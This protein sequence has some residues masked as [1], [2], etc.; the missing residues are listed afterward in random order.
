MQSSNWTVM[1]PPFPIQ[2]SFVSMFLL[3]KRTSSKSKILGLGLVWGETSCM[4]YFVFQEKPKVKFSGMDTIS[5][6]D[7]DRKEAR[8]ERDQSEVGRVWDP[9]HNWGHCKWSFTFEIVFSFFL[10]MFHIFI[11]N[12][13]LSKYEEKWDHM[14]I[15]IHLSLFPEGGEVNSGWSPDRHLQVSNWAKR[16]FTKI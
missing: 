8:C 9:R 3:F 2:D 4:E 14:W 12:L 10:V 16:M 13:W 1:P 7:R 6:R 5:R 11:P 15:F